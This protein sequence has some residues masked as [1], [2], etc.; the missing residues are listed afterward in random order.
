MVPRWKSEGRSRQP[1]ASVPAP[2]LGPGLTV[3]P[4]PEMKKPEE[5][6]DWGQ[7]E[8]ILWGCDE[9]EMLKG[10]LAAQGRCWAGGPGIPC[11]PQ[12]LGLPPSG[13][14]QNTQLLTCLSP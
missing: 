11:V 10:I 13:S 1:Q 14:Y 3:V 7:S 9:F 5:G 4:E 2:I 6:Q 12:P 8:D